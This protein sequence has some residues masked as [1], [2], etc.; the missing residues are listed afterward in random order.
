MGIERPGAMDSL[1]IFYKIA[2]D[3]TPPNVRV[4]YMESSE[5]CGSVT[6]ATREMIVP[7]PESLENLRTYLHECAHLLLHQDDDTIPHYL[8]EFQAETWALEKIQ[9]GGLTLSD[10][11]VLQSKVRIANHIRGA[12]RNG[13]R[14][15]DKDAFQFAL[16]CF[17]DYE[18]SGFDGTR[19]NPD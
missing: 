6:Y 19:V 8:R 5:S 10:E 14:L 1:E 17:R 2:K 15:L 4:Y 3:N 7:R 16:P 13:A 18:L 12:F 11:F 9:A